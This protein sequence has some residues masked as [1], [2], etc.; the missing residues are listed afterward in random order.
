MVVSRLGVGLKPRV[1]FPQSVGFWAC[2]F[3]QGSVP[4]RIVK[5]DPAPIGHQGQQGIQL[6][7]NPLFVGIHVGQVNGA[8][9]QDIPVIEHMHRHGVV[10]LNVSTSGGLAPKF[11]LQPKQLIVALHGMQ[12][13]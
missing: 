1:Q 8:R 11:I 7:H 13:A 4:P 2:G 12:T 10:T 5:Q 9:P 6:L 3:C